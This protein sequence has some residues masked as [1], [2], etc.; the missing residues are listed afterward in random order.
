MYEKDIVLIINI[1]RNVFWSFV[2]SA[3]LPVIVKNLIKYPPISSTYIARR[4]NNDNGM[5][6]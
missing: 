6:S 2:S 4:L 5:V 1:G 3:N